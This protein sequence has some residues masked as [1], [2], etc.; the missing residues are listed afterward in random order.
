MARRGRPVRR[1]LRSLGFMPNVPPLPFE[2]PVVELEENLVRLEATPNPSPE[3][4]KAIRE[5]RTAITKKRREIFENLD[6][7]ETVL[8]ARHLERPQ[9]LDYVEL[10][11]DE[12]FEL[13]GDRAYGDDRAI[14]TGF[15]KLDEFKVMFIG[16]HK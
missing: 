3:V 11:F 10:V 16:Q 6:A 15:A 14:V 4:Q 2:R 12:F 1:S 5:L 13:H 9:T 7:W 8:V